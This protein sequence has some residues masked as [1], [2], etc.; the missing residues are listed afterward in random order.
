MNNKITITTNN[1]VRNYKYNY[2]VPSSI[3]DDYDWLKEED[4]S[5]GWIHYRNTWY[6]ISDFLRFEGNDGPFKGWHGHH[7]HGFFSGVLIKLGEDESEEY[8]IGSFQQ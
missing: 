1:H 3:L 4:K 2:E 7:G 8:I 6:H 5:D